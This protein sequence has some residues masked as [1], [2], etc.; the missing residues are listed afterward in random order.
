MEDLM[1]D[2]SQI[3]VAVLGAVLLPVLGIAGRALVAWSDASKQRALAIVQE[4]LG[5]AAARIAAELAA[6]IASSP[7][8]QRVTDSMLE[9]G[10]KVL[11][12]RF[13]DTVRRHDI[14]HETLAG[15]VAGELGK[16]GVSVQR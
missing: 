3:V 12:S 11:R 14:R 6:D 9:R 16:I 10:A 8:V 7:A 4:R 13:P 5:A 2:L 15:M 1:Q